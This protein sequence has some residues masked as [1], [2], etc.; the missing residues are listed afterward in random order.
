MGSDDDLAGLLPE[1]PPP[2]P[3]RR[4]A[5]IAAAMERFDGTASV[6]S[7]P[8]RTRPRRSPWWTIPSAQTAAFASVLLI[9]AISVTLTLHMS[10]GGLAPPSAQPTNVV[11][12]QER[13]PAK[14]DASDR[15]DA[16]ASVAPP[17]SAPAA[18]IPV[19][20][21]PSQGATRDRGVAAAPLEPLVPAR[22]VL[23]PPPAPAP[24]PP[25]PAAPAPP[26][27]LIAVE[28]AAPYA[29]AARSAAPRVEIAEKG[30]DPSGND[31]V[32]TG[33]RVS[34]GRR[35][36]QRGNWNACTVDDP[37]KDLRDCKS[38][39][40]R[41]TNKAAASLSEG[42]TLGWRGDWTAA[43]EAFTQAIATKPR[44]GFAYLNRGLA[45]RHAGDLDRAADDLDLAVR[46]DGD[47][48]SYYNRALLKRERGD[49]R[50][51]QIDVAR[52]V[53]LDPGYGAVSN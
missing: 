26:A 24:A 5:A 15:P 11:R 51:A 35:I 2:R 10:G 47:A 18:V 7:T 29:R 43:A 28:P 22:A 17:G 1:P 48:R 32:V 25:P 4:E 50:G 53:E 27:A 49:E 38:S 31:V 52:A 14:P 9:A 34:R 6:S 13:A 19:P 36:N 33:S 12:P 40:S 37:R 42:L 3:S 39:I 23:A 20:S 44:S 30:E 8:D 46:Y 41:A 21:S 16:V 45:Y